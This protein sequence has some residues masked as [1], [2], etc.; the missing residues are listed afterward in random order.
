[1]TQRLQRLI[2][3]TRRTFDLD[4]ITYR[5]AAQ[6]NSTTDRVPYVGRF[7]VGAVGT[8]VATGFGGWG[9]TNGVMA[10]RLLAALIGGGPVPGWAS[11]YDPRRLHPLVEAPAFIKANASVARHFVADRLRPSHV[12]AVA[13]VQPGTGAIVRVEGERCAVYR[14]EN[15]AVRVVSATCTH[16]G[17]IVHFNNAEKTWDCPCH[18]SRF[19]TDGTVLEGPATAALE[20]RKTP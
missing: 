4:A 10:G 20:S 2:D 12:D 18:G 16:L 19:A 3:W 13:D 9:M 11:L 6:D 1:V 17:C 8:W 7:H 15:G 14:D 5:W